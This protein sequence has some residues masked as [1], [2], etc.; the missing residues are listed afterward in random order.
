[1]SWRGLGDGTDG[2]GVDLHS[3]FS[4]EEQT[5]LAAALREFYIVNPR[6]SHMKAGMAAVAAVAKIVRTAGFCSMQALPLQAKKIR[7][8]SA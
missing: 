2:F 8:K 7:K 6:I 1:M 4:R 5:L 3:L